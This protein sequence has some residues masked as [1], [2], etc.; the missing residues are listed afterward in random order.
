MKPIRYL[1][2]ALE[3]IVAHKL[4][5]ILTMGYFADPAV[6][7][8]LGLSPRAI[9]TPVREADLLYPPVGASRAVIA[10]GP[11]DLT[12]PREAVP[13]GPDGPLHPDYA[14]AGP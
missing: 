4:R 9:A 10:Y 3:S 1:R 8:R 7:R 13:L 11:S 5:A 12:P 14:E 2:V 6:L